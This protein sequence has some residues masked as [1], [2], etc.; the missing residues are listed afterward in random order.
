MRIHYTIAAT[1]LGASLSLAGCGGNEGTNNGA[2][3]FG[4]LVRDADVHLEGDVV[5]EK[6]FCR[7]E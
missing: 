1:V 4:M 6:L 7:R 2:T 5:I 3:A